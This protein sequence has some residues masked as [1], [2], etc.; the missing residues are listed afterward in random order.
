MI[1]RIRAK[2]GPAGFII[3][4]VALVAALAGG[5]YAASGGGLSGKQKKEVEKIAKKLAGKNGTNGTNGTN[6][7]PGAKGDTGAKGDKGDP[8]SPGS[9]GSPGASGKSVVLTTEAPGANCVDGGVKA[10]VEGSATSKKFVCNG[11]T[12]F[13]DTLPSEKTET[14]TWLFEAKGGE[15]ENTL[16]PISF[17]IPLSPADAAAVTVH[18]WIQGKPAEQDPQCEGTVNDPKAE[19]GTICLYSTT[20]AD[21]TKIPPLSDP[22]ELLG[23]GHVGPTG[24]ILRWEEFSGPTQVGGSFAITAP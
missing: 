12:G 3:A 4:I 19:A 14:G 9:A 13:T 24:A 7:S 17:P 15:G 23:E 2:L 1:S 11:Q 6:G 8:G 16:V 10:E 22:A 20:G 5:A 18:K 21:K